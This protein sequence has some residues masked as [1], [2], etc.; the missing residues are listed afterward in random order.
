MRGT[1]VGPSGP[2][3][4]SR[5]LGQRS[6]PY[7]T[8]A[9]RQLPAASVEDD[10]EDDVWDTGLS[11]QLLARLSATAQSSRPAASQNLAAS[12]EDVAQDDA[13]DA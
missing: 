2:R 7:A 3:P 13:Q 6:S 9:A 4:V 8:H 1:L 11:F 5:P 12:G 10:A